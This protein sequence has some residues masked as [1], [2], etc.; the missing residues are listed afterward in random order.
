[1]ARLLHDEHEEDP[2]LT[3]YVVTR[4]WRAPEVMIAQSYGFEIDVWSAGTI[5]AELALRKPLFRGKDY[6]DQVRGSVLL[7]LFQILPQLFVDLLGCAASCARSSACWA[8]PRMRKSMQSLMQGHGTLC[9]LCLVVQ[10]HP[11]T[12]CGPALRLLVILSLPFC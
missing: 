6:A 11:G 5:Y 7:F 10:R 3:E 9:A 1:M 4:W 8:R 2:Q 12:C